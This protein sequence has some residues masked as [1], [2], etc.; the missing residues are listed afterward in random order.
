MGV[1]I[2]RAMLLLLAALP[3]LCTSVAIQYAAI[4]V[5]FW[6]HTELIHWIASW[7]DGSFR[8]SSLWAPH[9]QTRPLVYRFVVLAMLGI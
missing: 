7:H 6:D 1:F 2:L 4:T 5:P 8:F 3:A 9:N